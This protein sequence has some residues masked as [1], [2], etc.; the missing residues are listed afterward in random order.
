MSKLPRLSETDRHAPPPPTSQSLPETGYPPQQQY[1]PEARAVEPA[2]F[3]ADAWIGIAVGV[4]MLLMYPRFLQW[5][6]SRVFGTHFNE[7][8][9]NDGTIV[10]YPKV[11]EFWGDLGPTSFAIVLIVEGVAMSL[12]RSRK[13]LLASF[14]LTVI[15]TAYNLIY[16][17]MTYSTYGLPL[18]SALAV[19]FGVYMAMNQW[20]TI[21]ATAPRPRA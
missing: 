7:F 20:K 8:V 15:A 4:I 13:V 10:P 14:A 1:V 9:L 19:V 21:Q 6:S 16:L 18:V 17:L 2:R 5:V 12:V 11:P 3:F